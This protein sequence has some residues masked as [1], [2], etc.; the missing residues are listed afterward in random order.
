M[1]TETVAN[2]P[3]CYAT[4]NHSIKF[5][6]AF[7]EGKE[8]ADEISE[9][10]RKNFTKNYDVEV[11]ESGEGDDYMKGYR[12]IANEAPLVIKLENISI[13]KENSKYDYAIGFA[14]D[15]KEPEYNYESS[16]IPK[17]IARDG[18]MWI[19]PANNGTSYS[20]DQNPKAKYQWMTKRSLE[21]GYKPTEEELE[22]GM[23]ETSQNTGLIY[24]TFMVFHKLKPNYMPTTRGGDTTRGA[25][26]GSSGARF[27]YG[28]EAE[29]ASVKSDFE[30]ATGTERY[31]LP[32]RLR[33][34]DESVKSTINC[35]QHLKGASLNALRRQTMTVPF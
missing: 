27:G 18:T 23:E 2:I 1:L 8:D 15:G 7:G 3:V 6:I 20:N 5:D 12:V 33:I 10:E 11:F 17:N 9:F 29:S 30:F 16:T 21:E 19:I 13:K 35:S 28:N 31:V 14:V 26:R 22:L 4:A 32:I 25:T 34:A 24:L